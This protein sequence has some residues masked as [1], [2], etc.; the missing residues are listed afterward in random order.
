M[1]VGR[2]GKE[3]QGL[4]A[5]VAKA[6]TLA[7]LLEYRRHYVAITLPPSRTEPLFSHD[8]SFK[9]GRVANLVHLIRLSGVVAWLGQKLD[10]HD[11]P[12]QRLLIKFYKILGQAISG[13]GGQI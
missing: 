6:S 7:E 11:R 4:K 1:C 8:L 9:A 12:W 13:M 2:R 10:A 3:G 5:V